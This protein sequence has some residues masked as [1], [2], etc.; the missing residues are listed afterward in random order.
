MINIIDLH[1]YTSAAT[2]A[3][4][5]GFDGVELEFRGFRLLSER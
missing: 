1:Y 2:S 5:H 4:A 3:A